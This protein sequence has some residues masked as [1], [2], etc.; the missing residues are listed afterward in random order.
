MEFQH[1][2]E[3]E[4][5]AKQSSL[6]DW[7]ASASAQEDQ[8]VRSNARLE[9]PGVCAWINNNAKFK[10]WRD[11]DP[12]TNAMLWLTGIPGSGNSIDILFI[13]ILRHVVT[14]IRQ[15]HGFVFHH[16]ATSATTLFAHI[17]LLLQT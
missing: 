7:L 10:A 15:E 17:I 2:R 3:T 9:Y 16:R 4:D 5:Q 14:L 13:F 11:R 12:S 1:L 8:D 6:L